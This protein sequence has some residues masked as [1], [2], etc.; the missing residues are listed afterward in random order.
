MK[1]VLILLALCTLT[2][3]EQIVPIPPSVDGFLLGSPT[4]KFQL[5]AFIDLMCPD[6][7]AAWPILKKVIANVAQYGVS[8][9]FHIFPLPFHDQAFL[10][11]QGANFFITNGSLSDIVNYT[12]LAFKYQD[13]YA[14]AATMNL[15]KTQIVNSWVDTVAKAFPTYT[16]DEIY[17]AFT[18]STYN[19]NA[20][21]SWKLG[22]HLGI[23]GTPIFKANGV[24]ID[25][26]DDFD[27]AG[28][29]SFL[30]KYVSIPNA[31]E[32]TQSHATNETNK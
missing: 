22:C 16:R 1:L 5:E 12:D 3:S 2:Y 19:S 21:T 29:I 15:T 14:N 28:W 31:T 32:L 6:S 8:L 10:F 24:T 26:A 13:Q 18:N 25:R 7:Q 11:A 27:Y 23:T 17:N 4:S 30:Q 20:R 9:R